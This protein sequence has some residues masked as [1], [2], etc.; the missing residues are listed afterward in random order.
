MQKKAIDELDALMDT[1]GNYKN[2]RAALRAVEPPALP[3]LGVFLRDL[4]FIEEGNP[5]NKDEDVINFE[6]LMLIGDVITQIKYFQSKSY[7]FTH[8]VLL[9]EY[10]L[11]ISTLP[12]EMLYKHSLLCEP[13]RG[14]EKTTP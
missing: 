14:E 10:L 13:Q 11:K 7:G 1:K 5:D 3:Y 2:Y 4:L 12:E 8:D 9:Q 6:K